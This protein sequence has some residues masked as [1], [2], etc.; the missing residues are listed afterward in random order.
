[1][2][3]YVPYMIPLENSNKTSVRWTGFRNSRGKRIRISGQDLFG[4]GAL[5]VNSDNLSRVLYPFQLKPFD[6][7]TLNVDYALS[8][9]GCTAIS[10]LNQYRTMPSVHHFRFDMEPVQQ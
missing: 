5:R 2:D 1:M 6:G 4:F 3:W 9:V 7:L 10:V 8:G